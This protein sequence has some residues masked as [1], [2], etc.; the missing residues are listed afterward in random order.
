MRRW[1]NLSKTHSPEPDLAEFW[2]WL[3]TFRLW[4]TNNYYISNLIQVFC[5]CTPNWLKHISL[6]ILRVRVFF[7]YLVNRKEPQIVPKTLHWKELNRQGQLYSRHCDKGQ[8][9]CK[10]KDWTQLPWNKWLGIWGFANTEWANENI[11]QA[12]S[13]KL[14][15]CA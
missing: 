9:Y 8:D 10:E 11:T 6:W 3:S 14:P 13:L 1:Q 12:L 5:Y 15:I 7:S 4:E 2:P